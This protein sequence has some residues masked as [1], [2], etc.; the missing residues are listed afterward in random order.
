MTFIAILVWAVIFG[1]YCISTWNATYHSCYFN[2]RPDA[3]SCARSTK[4]FYYIQI[5]EELF[6]RYK[7]EGVQVF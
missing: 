7:A 6:P 1:K 4:I 2:T 3:T 5:T